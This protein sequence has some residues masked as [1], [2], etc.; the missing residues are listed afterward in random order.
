MWKEYNLG[1]RAVHHEV[2]QW[3]TA[4]AKLQALIE[5]VAVCHGSGTAVAWKP[6]PKCS[7]SKSHASRL[8]RG[9]RQHRSDKGATIVHIWPRFVPRK[10]LTAMNACSGLSPRLCGI[11]H[12]IVSVLLHRTRTRS[13]LKLKAPLSVA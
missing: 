8:V 9:Q 13:L 10:A 2:L 1:G 4:D 6:S 12:G 5:K 7:E 11:G 3:L